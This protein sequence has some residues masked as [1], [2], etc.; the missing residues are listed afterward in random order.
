VRN[1]VQMFSVKTTSP[2]VK[3]SLQP[4]KASSQNQ[5]LGKLSAQP[6]TSQVVNLSPQPM[7]TQLPQPLPPRIT[8]NNLAHPQ[9]PPKTL[10][11]SGKTLTSDECKYPPKEMSPSNQDSSQPVGNL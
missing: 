3:E 4:V 11:Q 6:A 1:L 10:N 5:L 2:P 8:S 7:Q 9:L